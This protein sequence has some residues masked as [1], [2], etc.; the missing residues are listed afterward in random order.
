MMRKHAPAG[1]ILIHSPFA[2]PTCTQGPEGAGLLK[3]V[4]RRLACAHS[5][6]H[7]VPY[8]YPSSIIVY[9]TYIVKFNAILLQTITYIHQ[10]KA[11]EAMDYI[12]HNIGGLVDAG[13]DEGEVIFRMNDPS[14]G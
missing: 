13:H 1:P 10:L 3:Q 14:N 12:T 11:S 7:S 4:P 9:R 6:D 8:T 5:L 2:F